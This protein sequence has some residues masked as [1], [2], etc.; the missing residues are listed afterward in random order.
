MSG[1]LAS[2]TKYT[3]RGN[4][5]NEFNYLILLCQLQS[6]TSSFRAT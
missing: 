3:P 5:A 1:A 2:G 6:K 4:E